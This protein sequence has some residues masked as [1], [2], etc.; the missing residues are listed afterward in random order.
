MFAPIVIR[1][2][3]YSIPMPSDIRDYCDHVLADV[4][5]AHWFEQASRETWIVAADEAGVDR[6]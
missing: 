1:L 5:V 6:A 4:D 2:S 3:N